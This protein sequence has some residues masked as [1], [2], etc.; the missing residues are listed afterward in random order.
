MQSLRRIL[1]NR[2]ARIA[3]DWSLMRSQ[4]REFRSRRRTDELQWRP[5][6]PMRY[7]RVESAI[8][9]AGERVLVIAGYGNGLDEVL[10]HIDRFDLR[11]GRWLEPIAMP[12]GSASSHLGCTCVENRWLYLAGGQVGPQCRP[13]TD[14][15]WAL[16]IEHGN[17][18]ALPSLPEVRYAPILLHATDRLHA[19]GGT[20]PERPRGRCEHWSLGVRDGH[21]TE[22]S[23]REE[24]PIP[25]AG[26][27][28][29][30]VEIGEDLFV[31]GGQQGD[32][33]T[34]PNDPAFTCDLRDLGGPVFGD[35]FRFSTADRSWHAIAPIPH[36]VSHTDTSVTT[37][38][39]MAIVVGGSRDPNMCGD[40]VQCYEP[41]LDRWH[42]LGHLPRPMKNVAATAAGD[43][44]LLFGGQRSR[45]REDLSNGPILREAWSAPLPSRV[46]SH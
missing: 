44:L 16:E 1:G 39:R 30:G 2:L 17:W 26:T 10:H 37:H 28:R 29:G 19:I 15:V 21:A 14:Q 46:V 8:A 4:A 34:F 6:Q 27:H 32:A 9:V 5:L 12:P 35:S 3:P 24:P 7:R 45:N 22:P 25:I 36:P 33:Q 23:W 40:L 18:H 42:L 20:G 11:R 31:F 38:G 43:A 13:A 41:D